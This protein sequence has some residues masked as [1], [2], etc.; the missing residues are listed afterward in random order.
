MV[1]CATETLHFI[2]LHKFN[3]HGTQKVTPCLISKCTD[4]FMLR[5]FRIVSLDEAHI[6]TQW[7]FSVF[8]VVSFGIGVY[9][10]NNYISTYQDDPISSSLSITPQ[11]IS[12]E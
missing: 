11:R 5:L 1:C 6:C 7:L 8:T 10:L 3:K 9:V 4:M 2:I 12:S